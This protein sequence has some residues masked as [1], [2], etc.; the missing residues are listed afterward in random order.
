MTGFYKK[1]NSFLTWLNAKLHEFVTGAP[2]KLQKSIEYSL[3]GEGKRLRPVLFLAVLDAYSI[4]AGDAEYKLAA[5]IECIHTYSLIHDDLPAMDNDDMRRGQPT[6]HIKFGESTALLAGDALLNFAGELLLSAVKEKCGYID[7][8]LLISKYA[9]INGMIGGQALE[10]ENDIKHADEKL[11]L[12]IYDKKCGKLIS[13]GILAGALT[14]GSS[15]K[16]FER[17]QEFSDGFGLCFQLKDDL[18]DEKVQ[19][20]YGTLLA[21]WGRDR[22]ENELKT[23]TAKVLDSLTQIDADTGFIQALVKNMLGRQSDGI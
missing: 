2:I 22:T 5:A 11:M 4:T 7:A 16:D 23:R 15:E 8:A 12:E 14:A 6:N 20:G 17:W 1:Y 21:L 9:G 18:L 3:F 19:T 10:F 13:A